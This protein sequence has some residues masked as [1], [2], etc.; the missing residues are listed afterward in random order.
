MSNFPFYD[1]IMKD[2]KNKDLTLKQKN[3]FIT[4]INKIDS[5]G[6]ELIYALIRIFQLQNEDN[7][8]TCIL[9][10]SGRFLKKNEMQF[11]LNEFPNK[12]KQLLYKFLTMHIKKMDEDINI[13][14]LRI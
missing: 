1:S 13:E 3:E 9:P 2:I 7:P 6:A 10:Y 11:D 14:K 5:D 8:L 4:N 12:L